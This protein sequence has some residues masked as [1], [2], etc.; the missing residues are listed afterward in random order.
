M[1]AFDR[2]RGRLGENEKTLILG[3]DNWRV[4]AF[5]GYPHSRV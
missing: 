1:D 4:P 2:S 5:S 3:E